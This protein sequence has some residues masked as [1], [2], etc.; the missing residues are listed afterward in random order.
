MGLMICQ[1]L[2]GLN[3]GTIK[4]HSD[5]IGKGS[6]FSFTMKMRL[7]K[8]GRSEANL[9]NLDEDSDSNIYVNTHKR[10]KKEE[11]GR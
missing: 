8:F 10:A 2:V 5:G 7:V 1:K 11:G 4:V 9:S 6:V 3:D